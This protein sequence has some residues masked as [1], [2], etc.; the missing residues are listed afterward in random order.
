MLANLHNRIQSRDSETCIS[1]VQYDEA[2]LSLS[3]VAQ[4]EACLV[5]SR[6]DDIG[7]SP[8]LPLVGREVRVCCWAFEPQSHSLFLCHCLQFRRDTL[9]VNC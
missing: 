2:R 4:A 7:G 3:S 5:S 1:S 8:N 9:L 6:A